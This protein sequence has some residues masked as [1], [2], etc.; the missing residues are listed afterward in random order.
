[1]LLGFVIAG[2][3][4]MQ[5]ALKESPS[6]KRAINLSKKSSLICEGLI[7]KDPLLRDDGSR[8][9]VDLASCAASINEPSEN[10]KGRIRLFS[11]A[12]PN[13]LERGD[14]V[15][16][17][18]RLYKPT[19]FKNPGSFDYGLYLAI[20]G[21]DALGAIAGPNW[22]AKIT[23]KELSWPIK[24][25]SNI[26]NK[27]DKSI[28]NNTTGDAA[29]ILKTISIGERTSLS[30]EAKKA[31][32][33][34]GSAHLL[35]ISGLHVGFL[36]L[37]VFFVMRTVLGWWSRLLLF[38]PVPLI[39]AALSIPAI[40]LYVAIADFP[41]SA[42]R[43]GIMLTVF[44]IAF[45]S[46][47]LKNDLLS[48]LA[49]AAFI[50]LVI[51][52]L[53]LFAASFQL[54]VAAVLAIITL[55]P[56]FTKRLEIIFKDKHFFGKW[57]FMRISQLFAVTVA[58]TLGTAP[59]VAYHFHYVT[60][61]GLIT[62]II[63]IPFVGVVLLPLIII[64]V[65]TALIWIS[66]GEFAITVAGHAADLFLN[67]VYFFDH[68]VGIFHLSFVPSFSQVV[69]VMLFLAAVALL[70]YLPYK[71]LAA[72]V[73]S[74]SFVLFISLSY[75]MPIMESNLKVLFIDIGQGDAIAIRFP[76]GRV[77]VIDG[78]G[79][80]ASEFDVGEHVL[81]PALLSS[82]IRRVDWLLLSHPH[83]DHYKGLAAVAEHFKPEVLYTNGGDAPQEEQ[84]DWEEFLK[85]IEKSGLKTIAVNGTLST[86]PAM[87]IKEGKARLEIFAVRSKDLKILDPNDA[88]LIV[89]LLYGEHSFLFTGDLMEVGERLWLENKADFKS[90]ILKIGHHGSNTSTTHDFLNAVD[91]SVAVITAGE[92]NKYGF[93]NK[94]VIGRLESKSIKIYRTD[95]DG[96]VTVTTNGNALSIDTYVKRERL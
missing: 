90:D 8:L 16:F 42:V 19:R 75:A 61:A 15:R 93:P 52:P 37:I 20:Q 57:L 9:N 50:I 86:K 63:T 41:I 35:A 3:F 94:E 78:G 71:R 5:S 53:S 33:R 25:I 26:R 66:L 48:A 67:I 43:A 40:W 39:S 77:G 95:L 68:T 7:V 29:G 56:A 10:V 28:S 11:A 81:V 64:A 31:F 27:I 30:E 17:R 92:N 89:R 44:V 80:K 23:H 76:N 60:A 2:R 70:K 88:S 72:A 85:R 59:L 32:L 21:V 79:I 65:T 24:F 46:L 6:L 74:G 62:N 54:S 55:I 36:A 49:L 14:Y 12:L 34:T 91:P 58:A 4:L 69:C 84:A 96:A 47:R 87:E 22:I 13:E 1:M 73:I 38:V 83:H 51:S 82:G 18:G 45:L